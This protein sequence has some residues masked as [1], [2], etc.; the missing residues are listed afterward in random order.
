MRSDFSLNSTVHDVPYIFVCLSL[1]GCP[2]KRVL[3]QGL[4]GVLHKTADLGVVSGSRAGDTH[5]AVPTA[6]EAQKTEPGSDHHN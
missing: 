1:E 4:G 3:Q 6:V 5:A 2:A